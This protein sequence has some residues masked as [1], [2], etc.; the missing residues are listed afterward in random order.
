MTIL[1]ACT[2]N[3]TR[4]CTCVPS[5]SDISVCSSLPLSSCSSSS[6]SSSS[7]PSS[8]SLL[9][10]SSSSWSTNRSMR[11]LTAAWLVP[12]QQLIQLCRKTTKGALHVKQLF[13]KAREQETTTVCASS[14]V[15]YD[16][17]ISYIQLGQAGPSTMRN[18]VTTFK[19]IH[20]I[21]CCRKLGVTCINYQ[22]CR[23]IPGW[24]CLFTSY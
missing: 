7:S 5:S 18:T 12:N 4:F 16:A 24:T 9:S 2:A 23:G 10:S 6:S 1:G 8:P 20:H 17:T 11:E 13:V 14:N 21:R 15:H 22:C 19:F 3:V